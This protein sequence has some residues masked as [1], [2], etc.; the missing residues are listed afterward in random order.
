[1]NT[2]SSITR[3]FFYLLLV[4]SSNNFALPRCLA[5]DGS[6]VAN[7]IAGEVWIQDEKST[8]LKSEI[9]QG[10]REVGNFGA[11]YVFPNERYPHYFKS[12]VE[13]FHGGTFVSVGTFRVLIT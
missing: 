6:D 8:D 7:G 2:A 4:F 5:A 1:M 3:G 9:E 11:L 13:N 10:D 12:K